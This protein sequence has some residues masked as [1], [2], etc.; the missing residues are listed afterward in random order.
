MGRSKP[1]GLQSRGTAV[2]RG[3]G[4]ARSPS[5]EGH[6]FAPQH[7]VSPRRAHQSTRSPRAL[8]PRCGQVSEEPGSLLRPAAP[9]CSRAARET[10]RSSSCRALAPCCCAGGEARLGRNAE[11]HSTAPVLSVRRHNSEGGRREASG[12]DLLH[13]GWSRLGEASPRRSCACPA[14]AS[15]L[16][17]EDHHEIQLRLP[18]APSTAAS[19]DGRSSAARKSVPAWPL[20]CRGDTVCSKRG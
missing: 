8:G 18:P 4:I 9:G 11:N 5:P 17:A 15:T 1:E 14:L 19:R 2:S 20:P 12:A 10:R 6:T 3:R 16:P 7:W 13:P